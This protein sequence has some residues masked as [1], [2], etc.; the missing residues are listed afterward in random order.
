MQLMTT[1]CSEG[2]KMSRKKQNRKM[3]QAPCCLSKSKTQPWT[4]VMCAR[5]SLSACVDALPTP[6]GLH[7]NDN[8]VAS[9]AG[10]TRTSDPWETRTPPTTGHAIDMTYS[11]EA[12]AEPQN[13]PER[14]SLEFGKGLHEEKGAL[15]AEGTQ[16]SQTVGTP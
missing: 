12:I 16:I 4:A 2:I 8:V 1:M 15:V 10:R 14:Q 3:C 5:N 11:R 13:V 7:N 9:D 6:S